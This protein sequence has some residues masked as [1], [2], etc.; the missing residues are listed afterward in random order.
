VIL[1]CIDTLVLLLVCIEWRLNFV[2]TI[3]IES[4]AWGVSQQ[5]RARSTSHRSLTLS[6][7]PGAGA[8]ETVVMENH[9]VK[10]WSACKD[11]LSTGYLLNVSKAQTSHRSAKHVRWLARM[12]KVFDNGPLDAM[13][14]QA[15][16]NEAVWS[17][18]PTLRGNKRS[19]PDFPRV[20]LLA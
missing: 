11:T 7:I 16:S 19:H 13:R 14:S 10:C 18:I 6:F 12:C 9:Y 8:G 20:V 5:S 4:P 17:N 15:F 2:P 1:N 3:I